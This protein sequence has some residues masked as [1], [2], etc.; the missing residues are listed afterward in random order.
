MHEQCKQRIS[1]TFSPIS[2]R[3]IVFKELNWGKDMRDLSCW[4]SLQA[5]SIDSKRTLVEI[6]VH[7]YPIAPVQNQVIETNMMCGL[8]KKPLDV[9]LKW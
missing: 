4:L 3:L 1:R 7:Y 2:E 6:M 8:M 9:S 5:G